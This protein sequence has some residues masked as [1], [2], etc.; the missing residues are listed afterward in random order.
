ML[1]L[2]RKKKTPDAP[3]FAPHTGGRTVYAVGD[4]HGR[5]DL[6]DILLGMMKAD[7]ERHA[8]GERAIL[9][10]L[11]DYVDRGPDSRGVIERVMELVRDHDFETTA[12]LGNHERAMLDFLKDPAVHKAW[13]SYGGR[14]TIQ[15][16]GVTP[17]ASNA[18]DDE[19]IDCAAKLE[20]QVAPHLEFLRSLKL[21]HTVGNYAF[22]HAGVRPGVGL[23]EQVEHD[24]LWIRTPFLTTDR[25]GLP[26][27]V[28]HGHTP[29]P[30]VRIGVDRIGLDTG[31]YASGILSAARIKDA[32]VDVIDTTP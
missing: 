6:L 24:L 13:L 11:G 7:A 19:L 15:S 25:H 20:S 23:E 32:E 28:V 1:Q 21:S 26:Y 5:L 22:V 16:Y 8:P 10:M 30:I 14:E 2:F 4:V 31:A 12:L 29:E 27:R 18:H 17:V 3:V 9:V